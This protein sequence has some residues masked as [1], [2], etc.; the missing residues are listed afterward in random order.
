MDL[1]AVVAAVAGD[2]DVSVVIEVDEPSV[3]SK[4][5]SHRIWFEWARENLSEARA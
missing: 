4:L 2:F 1:S 3:R 5:E